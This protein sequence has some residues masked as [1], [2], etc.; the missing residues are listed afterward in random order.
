MNSPDQQAT[1]FLSAIA[2]DNY[3]AV[4]PKSVSLKYFTYRLLAKKYLSQTKRLKTEL[5]NLR[6]QLFYELALKA[7]KKKS[8]K[9]TIEQLEAKAQKEARD[10]DTKYQLQIL[11]AEQE[12][13]SAQGH[14]LKLNNELLTLKVTMQEITAKMGRAHAQIK[15]LQDKNTR[16]E[17]QHIQESEELRKLK[18]ELETLRVD[19]THAVEKRNKIIQHQKIRLE[20]ITDLHNKN[21]KQLYD[22]LAKTL[23]KNAQLV[24]H[25]KLIEEI[26]RK[27]ADRFKAMTTTCLQP[28]K[29][30]GSYLA[31]LVPRCKDLPE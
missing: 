11:Q 25:I 29:N 21:T 24:A 31:K 26:I 12:K 1:I 19:N 6:K 4:S 5:A 7:A 9:K 20:S 18:L 15:E 17:A 16:I 23:Q 13:E 28:Y 30:W 8:L 22:Q 2:F 10:L 27:E 3:V 14:A